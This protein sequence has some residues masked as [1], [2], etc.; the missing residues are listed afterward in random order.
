MGDWVNIDAVVFDMDGVLIDT[1]PVWRRV[2]MSVL[3][4]VGCELTEADMR[5]GRRRS[6]RRE[7]LHPF[8][9]G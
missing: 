3:N 5:L 6:Y 1:E 7:R 8:P 4:G 2:E 9:L